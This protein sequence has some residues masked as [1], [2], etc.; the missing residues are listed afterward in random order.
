MF[1]TDTFNSVP[2]NTWTP[3][4]SDQIADDIIFNWFGFQNA[5]V[6]TSFKDDQNFPN[7]ELQAFQNP[8][9][10]GGWILNRRFASKDITLKGVLKTAT[11][12]EM[13]TLIDTFKL[14]TSGVEW[15]LDIKIDWTYRRTK[16][17]C[18]KS[19]VFKR[20]SFDITRCPFEITFKTVE[21][22]FYLRTKQTYFEEWVTGNINIDLWYYGTATAFPKV[23]FFFGTVFWT[24]AISLELGWNKIEIAEA[25][26]TNDILIIDCL[27]KTVTLNWTAI[28]YT[29]SFP[30]LVY[31][32]NI[33][34]ILIDWTF[35]CDIS[36]L[37]PKNYL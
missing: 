27:E 6:V 19:D 32:S 5:N 20:Q 25:I 24:D 33:F 4:A 8:I 2:F 12:S 3:F 18:V 26:T 13:E 37:Y 10:D 21:P 1:N 23:Y 11:A 15:F 22:F 31:G 9:I 14:K 34:T 30:A 35:T 36:I 17:T 7:I 16:A 28:D 29:W